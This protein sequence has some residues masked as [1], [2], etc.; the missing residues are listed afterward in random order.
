MT[1]RLFDLYQGSDQLWRC[2]SFVPGTA[3]ILYYPEAWTDRREGQSAIA[4]HLRLN[5]TETRH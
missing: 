3:S 2:Y 1:P 5:G 4:E